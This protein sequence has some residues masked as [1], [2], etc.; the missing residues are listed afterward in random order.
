MGHRSRTP[1]LESAEARPAGRLRR[2]ERYW[3]RQR[4]LNTDIPL[5]AQTAGARDFQPSEEGSGNL[6]RWFID[7]HGLPAYEYELDQYNDPRAAYPTSEGYDRRDHW[8]QIGNKRVTATASNDG[9]V[10]VYLGDRGG[11]FLNRFEAW[12]F[13]RP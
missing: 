12:E 4:P 11:V 5:Q 6:G 13:E 3:F 2:F 7:E 9:T 1:F 10:Q 8:H